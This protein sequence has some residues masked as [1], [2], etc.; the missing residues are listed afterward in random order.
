MRILLALIGGL[1]LAVDPGVTAHPVPAAAGFAVIGLTGLVEWFV[2]DERWLGAEEALS[3]VAVVCMVGWNGGQVDVVSLLWLVAAAS[4][5]LARGGRVGVLGRAIVLGTLFSPLVTRG[6]MSAETLAFAA[7]SIALL[8]ATGRISRETAELLSRARHDAAHDSLTGLLSRAAFRAHVDRLTAL[9]TDERPASLIAI[10]LD[11]FGAV[12]KRLGHAAGDRLLVEAARSMEAVLRDGDVLGRLG[13]DEFAALVFSEDP[14][15]VAERLIEAIASKDVRGASACAGI[16]TAPH[17]G[18]GAEALLAAADVALRVTKR[19]GRSGVNA[20][21]GA[22]ISSAGEDGARAAL[23]R[24]CRGEG[25]QLAT[26]PIVDLETAH[27]HAYEALAR[28]A[29]RGGQGPLHW[30]ALADELGMR[31]ELELACLETA[32]R[33]MDDLPPDTRLSVNLSAPMLVDPRTVRALAACRD[34]DRLI[35]E[36]TEETLVRHGEAIDRSISDLR[37]RG[38]KFAVDDVGAGY[39][40]LSQL[41]TLRPTYLKLDRGL[42]RGI[43]ADPARV[44]LV[45]ALSDYARGTGGLLV[46]EGVETPEELA[47]V[48][49]AGAPL[50]QGYL[51]ARPGDPWPELGDA[52]RALLGQELARVHD[53]GRVEPL[54]GG[55]DQAEAELSHLR[56]H[57]GPVVAPDRVVVGDGAARPDDRV[58]RG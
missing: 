9:A 25:L 45:R 2:R 37:E 21:E 12:N 53:P 27:I 43:D 51:L 54:L 39:S 10:D 35:I 18:T 44:E 42:V 13:G 7:G 38:V 47:R 48:R 31:A 33:L 19:A 32:L 3:C 34:I 30:F 15:P 55:P 8:L 20:Y 36:V 49:G 1:L 6:G 16:A 40:G 14:R 22:P 46:A 24:L 4:G 50:V 17:D 23:E 11:D 29:T 26:Q 28:F 57:P 56:A 41:A 52:A 5:V 58:A